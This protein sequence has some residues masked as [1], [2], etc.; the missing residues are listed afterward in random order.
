MNVRKPTS[1]A[2][3]LHEKNSSGVDV[4]P[5]NNGDPISINAGGYVT[6][7]A[8][9]TPASPNG[10]VA[11][12]WNAGSSASTSDTSGT[13][14]GG[15]SLVSGSAKSNTV[16]FNNSGTFYWKAFFTGTGLNNN[17][18]SSCEVLHVRALTPTLDTLP[19]DDQAGV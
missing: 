6:D 13:A 11:F 17:S 9:V 7:Y 2:T 14:A 8:A 15:G 16:Q 5:V 3:T 12:K 4:N 10:S 19:N 18:Q 1:T